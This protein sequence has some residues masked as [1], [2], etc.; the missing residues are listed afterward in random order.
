M[1]SVWKLGHIRRSFQMIGPT[2]GVFFS[3]GFLFIFA[4]LMAPIIVFPVAFVA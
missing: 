4:P 3:V 1:E 2:C